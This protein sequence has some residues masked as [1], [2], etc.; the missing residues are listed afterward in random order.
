M[1]YAD[2]S[3]WL[4]G[5]GGRVGLSSAPVIMPL[6]GI[7]L[8]RPALQP[9]S[10]PL[11]MLPVQ[12]P[13]QTGNQSPA[14]KASPG[15]ARPSVLQRQIPR[16]PL[17]L[18]STAPGGPGPVMQQLNVQ[19]LPVSLAQL[20]DFRPQALG[21]WGVR[22][23]E[24]GDNHSSSPGQRQHRVSAVESPRGCQQH[25]VQQSSQQRANEKGD[26]AC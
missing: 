6:L 9:Q 7:S 19:F 5:L 13:L 21:Q 10:S 1:A 25:N 8:P 22:S 18:V 14:G 16:S 15:G 4:A 17:I 26:K 24:S 23:A 2:Q 11:H 3:N 12:L 20:A